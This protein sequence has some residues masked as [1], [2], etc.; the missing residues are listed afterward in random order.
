MA[1]A[2]GVDLGTTY[3]AAATWRDG[4]AEIASLGS[5]APPSRRS[6]SL[7]EDGTFLVGEAADRRAATEPDRVARE[8]KRRLGDTTPIL[9]G[10][11]PYSAEALMASCCGGWSTRSREREGG[12]PDASPSPTRRTGARTR[13]TCSPGDPPGRPR[14]TRSRSTE[15]EAAAVYYASTERVD[16]GDV[17]AVY[18]LGGGTFDAAVLRKT[19]TG[20]QILGKP[21]GIERLGGIDFDE[22][23]FAHV[24][25]SLGGALEELDE[26]D[27][28][29]IAAVARLREECVEAKEAL[30]SDTD[31]SIPV[32]LPNV[33]T[34]VRLTRGEFEDMIRPPLADA[35]DALAAALRG[36]GVTADEVNGAARRRL[37]ADPARGPAGR[38]RARPSGRRRRPPQARGR[39]R[40]RARRRGSGRPAR[41]CR[42][43]RR[44]RRDRRRGR[45]HHRC[46]GRGSRGCRRRRR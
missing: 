16:A 5:R 31:A 14:A 24:Q 42:G 44:G 34:E 18:D 28:A 2:L 35:L 30:S 13:P 26:D 46:R 8:F 21:E 41:R 32:L 45:W 6:C 20:S 19:A 40:R 4:H 7:R 25:R 3:T 17:V 11:T 10:G 1:Y 38:G 43:D 39:A 36:A 27:P 23:V 29:A 9:L 37:V 12:A 22:A 33:Q 15:P